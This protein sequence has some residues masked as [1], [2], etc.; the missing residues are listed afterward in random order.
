MPWKRSLSGAFLRRLRGMTTLVEAADGCVTRNAPQA[1]R[2]G[3][4]S[5]AAK[6]RSSRRPAAR[7]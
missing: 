2:L 4:A 3:A 1:M 7:W 5:L 6:E